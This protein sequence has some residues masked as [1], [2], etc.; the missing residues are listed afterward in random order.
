LFALEFAADQEM[1]LYL[2]DF[3]SDF[4]NILYME[5]RPV[6][7]GFIHLLRGVHK[8]NGNVGSELYQP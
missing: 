4:M 1:V 3:L 7:N 2:P 5:F 8:M 6:R